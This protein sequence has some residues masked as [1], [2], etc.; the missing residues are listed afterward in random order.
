[1]SAANS[2]ADVA[3]RDNKNAG[4]GNGAT[5]RP[6]RSQVMPTVNGKNLKQVLRDNVQ[7]CSEV[8]TDDYYG[9]SR[10]WAEVHP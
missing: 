1:M 6:V 4:R 3:A 2:G 7:I 9:L 10:A 8:H 5:R